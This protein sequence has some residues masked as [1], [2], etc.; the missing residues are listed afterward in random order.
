MPSKGNKVLVDKLDMPSRMATPPCLTDAQ[1]A[2]IMATWNISSQRTRQIEHIE[3]RFPGL[4][5]SLLA[6]RWRID[7]ERFL[8]IRPSASN[9]HSAP[10]AAQVGRHVALSVAG[11]VRSFLTTPVQTFWLRMV[12]AMQHTQRPPIVFGYL[13]LH[14]QRTS[15]E[16]Q[17]I[18][19][20]FRA[21]HIEHHLILADNSSQEAATRS[22]H[23]YYSRRRWLVPSHGAWCGEG[24]DWSWCSTTF[25]PMQRAAITFDMIRQYETETRETFTH[26]LALR[27]DAIYLPLLNPHDL[28]A[29]LRTDDAAIV[30]SD[31]FAAL[32]RDRAGYWFSDLLWAR[33][34]A[35]DAPGAE[36]SA[37]LRELAKKI[38]KGEVQPIDLWTVTTRLAVHGVIFAG[39]GF[40]GLAGRHVAIPYRVAKGSSHPMAPAGA[41]SPETRC[42]LALIRQ[43]RHD[44][45]DGKAACV[46][47][48]DLLHCLEG[49]H[50]H[51]FD[52]SD[53]CV[54]DEQNLAAASDRREIYGSFGPSHP[55]LAC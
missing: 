27:P 8:A 5:T 39:F 22:V 55:P 41:T 10:A 31:M 6:A 18:N 7:A 30:V 49:G 14:G 32:P 46:H 9:V 29:V 45:S 20:A 37:A 53:F 34:C 50:G 17:Q 51:P 28:H 3:H 19:N 25:W 13:G 11:L 16:K 47:T 36:S 21:L 33:L 38:S 26:V 4:N 40:D 15:L 24:H 23:A 44:A 52:A 35:A 12:E 54:C 48:R 43:R 42:R 1:A 2:R